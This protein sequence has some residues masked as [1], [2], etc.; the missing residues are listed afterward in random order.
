M[1]IE[2]KRLFLFAD[3]DNTNMRNNKKIIVFVLLLNCRKQEI[4][5]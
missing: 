4:K 2:F 1:L 5:L 3:F